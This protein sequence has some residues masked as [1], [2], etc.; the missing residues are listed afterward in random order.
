MTIEIQLTLDQR[1]RLRELAS[2]DPEV[3]AKHL[4]TLVD[5]LRTDTCRDYVRDVVLADVDA[6]SWTR[7][8]ARDLRDLAHLAA[9]LDESG[10]PQAWLIAPS[11]AQ[12]DDA[13]VAMVLT[14]S[15]SLG[16]VSA[17][18][19]LRLIAQEHRISV[20][21]SFLEV[22]AAGVRPYAAW[23]ADVLPRLVESRER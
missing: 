16:S 21:T 17:G 10:P 2:V 15:R 1:H 6:A 5:G 20:R 3:A 13:Q 12:L 7:D 14:L 23:V 11:I 4:A 9:T 19:Y 22:V 18:K 8:R